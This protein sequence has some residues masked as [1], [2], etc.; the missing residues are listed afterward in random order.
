MQVDYSFLEQ[1]E[2]KGEACECLP[3]SQQTLEPNKVVYIHTPVLC[4][5]SH[6]CIQLVK[7]PDDTTVPGLKKDNDESAFRIAV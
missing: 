4:T 7:L 2:A 5:S 1:Q 6:P 3:H